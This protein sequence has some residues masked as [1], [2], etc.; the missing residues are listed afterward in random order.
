MSSESSDIPSTQIEVS[1][2]SEAHERFALPPGCVEGYITANGQ[3][4]HYVSAGAG[5]L[6]LLL[7]GFPEFWYSW[8]ANIPALALSHRVVALDM[9]GYNLSDKPADGY[10]LATLATDIRCVIEAFGER[11]A[12]VV[13]HDWG[14]AI[15]WVVA[16]RELDYVRRLVIVNAPHL[17]P[18]WR[19]IRHARQ[20][21]RSAY[22]GF[23]QLA[24]LAERAISAENYGMIW[25]AFRSADRKREWLGD[26]DIRRFV[27]AIAR[28]GALTAALSYYRQ[29]VRRGPSAIGVTRVITAPTLVLWG[30]QDPYLGVEL[31][32]GLDRWVADLRVVRVADAGHWLNQQ[33]PER[34]NAEIV[35][36]LAE[37]R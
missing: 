16:M 8:R 12:D 36:F 24:G 6:V 9:R 28:P 1:A 31:L 21:R 4:L 15:A 29:L 37:E 26:A 10:D 13:G 25:S 5:P 18:M 17:G 11:R 34:V 32:D 35:A 19:E 23:F 33:Q 22:I 14:G 7:H 30:E 27:E 2:A 3:R 20:L